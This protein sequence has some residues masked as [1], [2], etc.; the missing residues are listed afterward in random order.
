[1]ER[2]GETSVIVVFGYIILSYLFT[3]SDKLVGLYDLV[4]PSIR[5]SL[6]VL[7]YSKARGSKLD[8][9]CTHAKMKSLPQRAYSLR[10]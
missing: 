9:V 4:L 10:M 1:M 5:R 6:S 7:Y 8:I 2:V 3:F